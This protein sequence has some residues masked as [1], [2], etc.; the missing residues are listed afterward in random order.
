MKKRMKKAFLDGANVNPYGGKTSR[1][2]GT[3]SW[4]NP[5]THG[6]TAQKKQN[7]VDRYVGNLKTRGVDTSENEKIKLA[8]ALSE[9]I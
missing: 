9:S 2:Q 4:F 8:K 5:A 3:E 7:N 6:L 1:L